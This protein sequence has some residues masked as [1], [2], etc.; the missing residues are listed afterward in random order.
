MSEFT[1]RQVRRLLTHAADVIE[2]SQESRR[3]LEHVMKRIEGTG[4]AKE[5]IKDRNAA[6]KRKAPK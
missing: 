5:S 6:P 2:R 1:R 3:Q 4:W